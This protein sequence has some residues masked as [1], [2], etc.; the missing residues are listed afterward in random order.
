MRGVE[1]VSVCDANAKS[2]QAFAD[3]WGV[4][5][6]F[7]SIE[8][9]L[10]EQHV[11]ALHVLTP[12]NSHHALAKIALESGSHVFLEKPMCVSEGEADALLTLAHQTGLLLGVNHNFLY[13]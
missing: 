4:P 5:A 12:P 2:A 7:E 8:E 10:R 1:L 13:C 3:T 9:M 11:H 6:T